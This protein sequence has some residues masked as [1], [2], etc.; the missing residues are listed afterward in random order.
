MHK[1]SIRCITIVHPRNEIKEYRLLSAFFRLIGIWVCENVEDGHGD[2]TDYMIRIRYDDKFVSDWQQ[3]SCGEGGE[4]QECSPEPGV[5]YE[6]GHWLPEVLNQMQDCFNV[7]TFQEITKI[8]QCYLSCDLMRGSYAVGYFG[9]ADDP[10]IFAY[11][12][13]SKQRF[14]D[15]YQELVEQEEDNSSKYLLTAICNCQR[16]INELHTVIWKAVST[17]KVKDDGGIFTEMLNKHPFIPYDEINVRLSKILE[18]DPKNY[19][20]YAIR[21]FVKQLDDDKVLEFVYDFENAVAL[22]GRRSYA[23]CLLYHIG[24]YFEVVRVDKDFEEKYYNYAYE[25]NPHNYRAAYK[26]A[27]RHKRYGEHDK[28]MEILEEILNILSKKTVPETLQP[29]E[30]AYL[31]KTNSVIGKMYIRKEKYRESIRYLEQAKECGSSDKNVLFYQWM[32][33]KEDGTIF[34]KAAVNKLNIYN[35][36]M[37][38]ADAYAMLDSYEGILRAY[39]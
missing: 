5:A 14:F 17:G 13:N 8:A 10:G 23:S 22:C 33:G 4:L 30:C 38:L 31:Y 15:A 6:E 11:M 7:S 37:D 2:Q 27:M 29:V 24:K 25:V 35:C 9:D 16:R 36:Q 20:A 3:I 28:A 32:F 21:G 1:D 34:K 19:A 26:V 18:M 39:S 12:G